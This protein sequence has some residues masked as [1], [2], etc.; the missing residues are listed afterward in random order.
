MPMS[1]YKT[2][3]SAPIILREGEG[4]A[5][6]SGAETATGTSVGISSWQQFDFGITIAVETTFVPTI[7]VATQLIDGTAV[8]GAQ[9]L[10]TTNTGAT[11]PYQASVTIANSSTTAT[12]THT[13]HGLITGDKVLIKG[14]SLPENN[15]VFVITKTDTNTYTYTMGSA[16]GSNPTGAIISTFV[17]IYGATD[18]SGII[19]ATRELNSNQPIIGRARKSTSSPYYKS[20]P[21]S[22]TASSS[23]DTFLTALM[24][25]DE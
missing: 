9:V 22:G 14:A 8:T 4:F 20:A 6:V 17:F 10:V 11:L 2:S 1:R 24:V 23:A 3:G 5:I 7:T 12:V 15:G 18:G 16:P 13:S 19:S 25:S 21:I